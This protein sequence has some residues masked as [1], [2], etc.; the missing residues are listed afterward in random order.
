MGLAGTL[1]L[2]PRRAVPRLLRA[3]GLRL[4][5]RHADGVLRTRRARGPRTAPPRGVLN[6]IGPVWDGNEVWLITA[7]G[8]MFAAF[9][10]MY[11][12][13]FS[14]L[15]LPLLAILFAHDPAGLRDR[16]ARQDR[17]SRMASVGRRRHR[18]RARG[19]PRSCGASRSPT[20]VRGVARRR[21]QADS[22][23]HRRPAQRLH[24]AGW[25]WRRQRCSLFYG[26]VF[27]ALKTEGAVRDDAVRF[28]ARSGAAATVAGGRRSGC[29]RSWPTASDWTW[30]VLARRG[31]RAAVGG[32]AGVEPRAATAGR[33]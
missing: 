5:G 9:P 14:G 18:D 31:D 12:T 1:V 25:R 15:Y 26:A 22:P 30:L 4:R 6:T 23:V 32:D 2:P 24:A 11:A 17:R 16:M 10:G 19:C 8:A 27:V 33:S 20:L 29:G 21:R 3:R 7:G 13:V 28:A